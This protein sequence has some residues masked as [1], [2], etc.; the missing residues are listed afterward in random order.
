MI[1]VW[2]TSTPSSTEVRI[3]SHV[4]NFPACPVSHHFLPRIMLLVACNDSGYQ[5][6]T[7]SRIR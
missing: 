3:S 4:V 5:S 7:K 6:R 1:D 2:T